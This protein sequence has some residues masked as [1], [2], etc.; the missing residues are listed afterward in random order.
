MNM[1]QHD[2]KQHHFVP[3]SASSPNTPNNPTGFFETWFPSTKRKFQ[4]K[5]LFRRVSFFLGAL[6]GD[7]ANVWI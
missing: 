1:P 5:H 6:G 2:K 4:A 3:I 7:L